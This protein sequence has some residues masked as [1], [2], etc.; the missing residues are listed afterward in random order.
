M[1]CSACTCYFLGMA[2]DLSTVYEKASQRYLRE[3]DSRNEEAQFKRDQM[4]MAPNDWQMVLLN[5]AV[6][7]NKEAAYLKLLAEDLQETATTMM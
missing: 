3:A 4:Q 6:I 5:E 1:S 7:L 2:I